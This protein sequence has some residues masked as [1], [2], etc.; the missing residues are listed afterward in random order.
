MRYDSEH[1]QRTRQKVLKAAA[2]AIR[3]EGP[4]RIGVAGVMSEVGLTHG[5]FYAHFASKDD[6]VS[7]AIDEMFEESRAT[8]VRETQ[9]RAPAKALDNYI[10]RYLSPEHRDTRVWGCPLPFLSADAPRLP[11][12]ARSHFAQGAAQLTEGLAACLAALGMGDP[13]EAASSLLAELV[14]ALSLARAETDPA[15]ADAILAHSRAALKRR[16]GLGAVS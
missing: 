3:A 2:R 7:A 13:E 8:L 6:L 16:F 5:G 11:E 10:D 4:H 12:P 15:R 1:K 14:G 9:N